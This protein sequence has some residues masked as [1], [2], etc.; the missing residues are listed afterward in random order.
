MAATM[1]VSLN[2]GSKGTWE[3]CEKQPQ[4]QILCNKRSS[5]LNYT[6]KPTMNVT[7]ET[8]VEGRGADKCW[9]SD[10]LFFLCYLLIQKLN[11]QTVCT[12][13]HYPG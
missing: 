10:T 11:H 3:R 13:C 7:L 6:H 2:Y 12:K 1:Q 5:K 9:A 4:S 8:E